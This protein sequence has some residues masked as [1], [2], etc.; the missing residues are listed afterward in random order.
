MPDLLI[1]LFLDNI[2]CD[3]LADSGQGKLSLF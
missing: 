2:S 1:C 3:E